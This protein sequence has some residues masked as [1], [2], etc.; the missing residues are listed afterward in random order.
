MASKEQQQTLN[1]CDAR[2]NIWDKVQV[3]DFSNV[4][5]YEPPVSDAEEGE[6]ELGMYSQLHKKK[7]EV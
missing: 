4:A 2:S 7:K 6:H 1:V 5:Y 3:S